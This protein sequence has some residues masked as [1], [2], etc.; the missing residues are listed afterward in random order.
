M[1]LLRIVSLSE[2][3]CTRKHLP[4]KFNLD[5]HFD[6]SFLVYAGESKL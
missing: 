5:D 2:I 3:S 6:R 4:K 1:A